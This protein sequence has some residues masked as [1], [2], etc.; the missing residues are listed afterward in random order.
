MGLFYCSQPLPLVAPKRRS[1]TVLHT[2]GPGAYIAIYKDDAA[3]PAF[4]IVFLAR[5]LLRLQLPD[6][7]SGLPFQLRISPHCRAAARASDA[8]L[9]SGLPLTDRERLDL[10]A[11][12]AGLLATMLLPTA[13][14]AQLRVCCDFLNLLFYFRDHTREMS[15]GAVEMMA[16]RVM[17]T[18]YNLEE[19][20]TDKLALLVR[21]LVFT[22]SPGYSCSPFE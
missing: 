1:W 7:L 8:W 2:P 18:L 12:K 15:P 16:D 21:G 22:F 20:T 14:S 13:D 11:R 19:P 10:Y 4:T 6:L 5:M 3:T 9:M 17:G